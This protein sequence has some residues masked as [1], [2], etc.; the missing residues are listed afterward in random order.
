MGFL[1]GFVVRLKTNMAPLPISRVLCK[2]VGGNFPC[3]REKRNAYDR[4]HKEQRKKK[5][6]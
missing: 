4:F 1:D 3:L 2:G 6:L 5:D